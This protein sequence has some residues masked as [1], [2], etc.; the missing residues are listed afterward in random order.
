MPLGG[1]DTGALVPRALGP[2][3]LHLHLQSP[4]ADW[5]AP[6]YSL[7]GQSPW[8]AKRGFAAPARPRTMREITGLHLG[9][10]VCGG[11]QESEYWGHYPIADV[12]YKSDAPVQIGVR[13]W[14]PFIP[15]DAKA[16]N[17]PGA[18]FEVHLRNTATPGRK[19]AWSSAFPGFADHHT[20]DSL[21]WLAQS[22]RKKPVMPPP[23][24]SRRPAPTGL[25]RA[26]GWKTRR[27]A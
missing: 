20:R 4:H 10:G 22:C 8:A 26:C 16:S 11:M 14:S 3:G 12:E 5:R 23:Q 15:G 19:G 24:I 21:D 13:S 7:S 6:E 18:V 17:T 9:I 25:A 1:I 27:G 2:T